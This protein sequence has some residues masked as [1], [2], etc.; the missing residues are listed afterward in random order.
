M[1]ENTSEHIEDSPVE[2]MKEVLKREQQEQDLL[3]EPELLLKIINEIH[4]EGVVGEEDTIL[5][6][7]NKTCLRLVINSDP[8]SSNI[9]VSDETGGGK[10]FCCQ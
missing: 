7:I 1:D 4:T 10:R 2:S 3:K 6:L 8:T 9:I 5:T